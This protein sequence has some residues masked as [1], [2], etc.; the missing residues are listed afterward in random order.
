MVQR[1]ITS[2]T[3]LRDNWPCYDPGGDMGNSIIDNVIDF[4]RRQADIMAQ[5]QRRRE[6]AFDRELNR[7]LSLFLAGCRIPAEPIPDNPYA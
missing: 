2:L 6:E 7:R 5:R 3:N 4:S 1:I